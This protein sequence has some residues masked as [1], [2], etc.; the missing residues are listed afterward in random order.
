MK[1]NLRTLG[2]WVVLLAG[3]A[4]CSEPD[5]NITGST[6]DGQF[7]LRMEAEKNWVHEHDDLPIRVTLQSLTGVFLEERTEHV[8]F[9]VNNGSVSPS[10]LTVSFEARD[11]RQGIAGDTTQSQW[12]TFSANSAFSSSIQ[13][14]IIALLG[15]LQVTYKIRFVD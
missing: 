15:D 12:I 10:S 7:A 5:E 8:E 4:A 3:V 2:L 13:G 14:E 1:T 9:L 11:D 6:A